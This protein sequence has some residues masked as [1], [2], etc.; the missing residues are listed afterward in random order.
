MAGLYGRANLEKRVAEVRK[1]EG[2]EVEVV[3]L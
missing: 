1:N 2:G 3:P